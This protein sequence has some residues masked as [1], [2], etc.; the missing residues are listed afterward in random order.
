MD[1]IVKLDNPLQVKGAFQQVRV[2]SAS[3]ASHRAAATHQQ[4][5]QARR[6]IAQARGCGSGGV[7]VGHHAWQHGACRAADVDVW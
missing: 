1:C 4:Q 7:H 2:F 5:R 3:C 6:T